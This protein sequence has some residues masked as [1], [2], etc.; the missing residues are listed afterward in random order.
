MQN[1]KTIHQHI[2]QFLRHRIMLSLVV[3]GMALAMA[4]MSLG[5]RN[6]VAVQRM[7]VESFSWLTAHMN[8]EHPTHTNTLLRI[9]KLPTISGGFEDA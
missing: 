3:C 6:D 5:K 1:N 8:H 9:A 4:T 2:E 7:Y